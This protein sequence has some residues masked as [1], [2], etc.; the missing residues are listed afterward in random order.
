MPLNA[1]PLL[2][3]FGF[4]A[5]RFASVMVLSYVLPLATS[6]RDRCDLIYDH[7]YDIAYA[8]FRGL[9]IFLDGFSFLPSRGQSN[10]VF[11]YS[12]RLPFQAHPPWSVEVK[13]QNQTRF[14]P[15]TFCLLIYPPEGNGLAGAGS[16]YHVHLKSVPLMTEPSGW[17]YL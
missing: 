1:C 17:S 4:I 3:V 14:L 13:R 16:P 7:Q 2:S 15:L 12:E 8:S 9:E 11:Q 10:P 6:F 5:S